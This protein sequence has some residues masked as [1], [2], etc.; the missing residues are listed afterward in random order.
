VASW[1]DVTSTSRRD[2]STRIAFLR[3]AFH[4]A[5]LSGR[6]ARAPLVAAILVATACGTSPAHRDAGVSPTDAALALDG[7]ASSDGGAVD[8]GTIAP[9]EPGAWTI[10]VLPDTQILARSHAEIFE[11][12]TAWIAERRDAWRIA[13]V[14]H[15]GDIVDDNGADQWDVAFRAIRT[16]DDEVPYVLAPGNHDLG[17]GGS[18]A[19]RATLMNAYFPVSDYE[20]QSWFGGVFET[21]RIEN[22]YAVFDAP[23]E[24]WLVIA[25][26]FGPRDAVLAWAREVLERHDGMRTLLVTHAYLYSDDTRYDFAARPDQLWSPYSYGVASL[27]GGVNDGEEMFQAIVRDF[28]QVE[29]VVSGHVL[30]DGLGRLTSEQRDGGLVHQILANYQEREL[31]GAG[32]L[33]LMTFDETG[34]RVRVGTYSPY[35]DEW[36]TDADNQF[37]LTLDPR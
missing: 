24:P 23:S 36:L 5:V 30:N 21:D 33:R 20:T 26:E 29:L 8:G 17:P 4:V 35:L 18:A 15:V 25:L 32:F 2:S 13:F 9:L 11:A 7:G 37:E 14:T 34:S 10:V 6:R 16:L 1:P 27:P 12:Q 19:D 22:S 3:V 31:G 28:D